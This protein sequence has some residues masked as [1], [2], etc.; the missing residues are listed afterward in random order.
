[1]SLPATNDPVSRWD[2]YLYPLFHSADPEAKNLAYFLTSGYP[3]VSIKECDGYTSILYG[4]KFL[5]SDIVRAVA[6][7]AGVHVY[8]DSDDVLYANA[9]YL[10]LHS[11]ETGKKLL[12]F[13]NEVSLYEVYEEKLY[14]DGVT[15]L[16]VDTEIG[17]T[18]MF[19]VTKKSKN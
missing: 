13:Q 18:K 5:K 7:Y 8:L 3:A 17:D 16:W 9:N 12:K 14:A 11:S 19:R 10:T 2:T 15:E 6:K 1:M 4:S